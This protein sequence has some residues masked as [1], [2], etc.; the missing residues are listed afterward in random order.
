MRAILSMMTA[1]WLRDPACAVVVAG[2]LS[3]KTVF[4][5]ALELIGEKNALSELSLWK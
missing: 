4:K 5:M 1:G 3:V 2:R